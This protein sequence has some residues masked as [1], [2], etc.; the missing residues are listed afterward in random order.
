MA[1]WVERH[2]GDDGPA[3]IRET[4]ARLQQEGEVGGMELWREV[5]ERFEQLRAPTRNS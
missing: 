4:I 2:H 1:L 5:S 3:F